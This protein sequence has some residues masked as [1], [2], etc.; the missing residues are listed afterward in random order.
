[1]S[2]TSEYKTQRLP[3]EV[4]TI[5][6]LN[7]ILYIKSQNTMISISLQSQYFD[8]RRLQVFHGRLIID[9]RPTRRRSRDRRSVEFVVELPTQVGG[10]YIGE[11]TSPDRELN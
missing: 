2:T 8:S 10:L 11:G 4:H 5:K 7:S 3:Q 9:S 1:M 6:Q